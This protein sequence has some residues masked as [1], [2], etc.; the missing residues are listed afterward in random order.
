MV[1]LAGGRVSFEQPSLAQISTRVSNDIGPAASLRRSVERAFSRAIAAASHSLHGHLNNAT[2]QAT[3]K[4]ATDETVVLGWAS[5]FGLTRKQPT[6]GTGAASGTGTNGN[7]VPAGTVGQYDDGTRFTVDADVTVAGGVLTLAI[8]SEEYTSEANADAGAS[9]R[10]V[11]PISGINSD[12]TLDA[13]IDDGSD[14]ETIAD[15]RERLEERMQTPPRGGSEADYEAWAKETPGV[16]VANAIVLKDYLGDGTISVIFTIDD[17]DDPIPSEDQ[18]AAV[19]AYVDPLRPIVLRDF[20]V[21]VPV[22]DD[23]TYDIQIEPET[24]AVKAAIRA[25][26][27]DLHRREAVPGETLLLSHI[28]EA[29]SAATGETDH[30]LIAPAANVEPASSIHLLTYNASLVTFGAIP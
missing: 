26:L 29:I 19:E 2:R 4:T 30:V 20:S 14:L 13:D 17:A 6:Q 16:D 27:K 23:V 12:F 24:E 1:V 15:L 11:S 10:L 25:A 18:R 7:T 21:I 28:T 22:A 9:W 5:M 8:T 3:P